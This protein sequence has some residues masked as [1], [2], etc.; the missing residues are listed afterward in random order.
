MNQ[1]NLYGAPPPV[2]PITP[3]P[4]NP[5]TETT[6]EGAT[7]SQFRTGA[8]TAFQ[9]LQGYAS[10]DKFA[11]INQSYLD[12]FDVA[13]R[14]QIQA[15]E[16]RIRSNPN[17][18]EGAKN[19]MIADLY[20]Q[21]GSTRSGMAADMGKASADK[22]YQ[23]S[24][25][26]F[27]LGRGA[28]NEERNFTRQSY[29]DAI[30]QGNFQQAA[31]AFEKM[32]GYRPDMQEMQDDY[33]FKKLQA[34]EPQIEGMISDAA[35]LMLDPDP[36]KQ[37][38]GRAIFDRLKA[39][40]YPISETSLIT[41]QSKWIGGRIEALTSQIQGILA[42]NPDADVSGL[43]ASLAELYKKQ[44]QILGLPVMQ[45]I[46]SIIDSLRP[47]STTVNDKAIKMMAN[48]AS[49]PALEWWFNGDGY[50]YRNM[51][52]RSAEGRA[53]MDRANNGD[54]D[55]ATELGILIGA[56]MKHDES[57]LANQP[58]DNPMVQALTRYGLITLG[59]QQT[60]TAA[61][62][63]AAGTPSS[64]TPAAI[65][66]TP[67]APAAPS[68]AAAAL[69]DLIKN[70]LGDS[71]YSWWS[72]T[73]GAKYQN[74][75][76]TTQAGSE[77]LS[78]AKSGDAT[79]IAKIKSIANA[80]MMYEDDELAGEWTSNPDVKLLVDYGLIK[81]PDA[82]WSDHPTIAQ[83]DRA[84]P[85][86]TFSG[87]TIPEHDRKGIIMPGKTVLQ[88]LQNSVLRD[89]LVIPI[90]TVQ[91]VIGKDTY[92]RFSIDGW[93]SIRGK[94]IDLGNGT[95]FIPT[96]TQ[97]DKYQG[98]FVDKNGTVTLKVMNNVEAYDFIN[99]ATTVLGKPDPNLLAIHEENDSTAG[100][101]K[102]PTPVPP[103]PKQPQGITP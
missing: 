6:S 56:A 8:D 53:L 25:D 1:G 28:L 36:E 96:G 68:I 55:A 38:Q 50:V 9:Q 74:K 47:G 11:A 60:G 7:G 77:L 82:D 88:L 43:S 69:P 26:V 44:N 35:M 92:N 71:L 14:A 45:N 29:E 24:R 98:S 2:Q 17:I 76:S 49:G 20:R 4:A 21:A 73:D 42:G 48:Y 23:A 87:T 13:T 100:T 46:D 94:V 70:G 57:S 19:A 81:N 65:N 66:I 79:A 58:A 30:T 75:L 95:Y 52:T 27:T 15:Q 37:A 72:G 5:I 10:G 12:R 89:N 86:D 3:P 99:K 78:Q 39:Q 16:Q 59:T 62:T 63:T 34:R 83:W 67:P 91:A 32:Y 31:D 40:G 93:N 101:I 54:T 41:A 90:E 18:P 61:T 22:M 102:L 85:E 80:A 64:G 103:K 33:N 51:L 84:H 97:N